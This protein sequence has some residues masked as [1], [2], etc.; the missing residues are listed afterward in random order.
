MGPYCCIVLAMSITFEEDNDIGVFG[1]MRF[2]GDLALNELGDKM[3]DTEEDAEEWL[4]DVDGAG[5][6]SLGTLL[7][8]AVNSTF[9]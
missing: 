8:E 9:P 3:E 4:E 6:G 7:L 2:G 5:E 1:R